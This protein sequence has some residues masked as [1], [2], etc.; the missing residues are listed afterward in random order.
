MGYSTLGACHGLVLEGFFY[1][2][3]FSIVLCASV[4]DANF[5]GRSNARRQHLHQGFLQNWMVS[6]WC[7][8]YTL[9]YIVWLFQ[10]LVLNPLVHTFEV[11][12]LTYKLGNDEK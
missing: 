2:V 6:L 12:C 8:I 11:Q 10:F 4:A 9:L 5:I 1:V 3:Y 7:T